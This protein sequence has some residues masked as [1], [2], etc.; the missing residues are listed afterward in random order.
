MAFL[1]FMFACIPLSCKKTE[2]EQPAPR[3]D[4]NQFIVTSRGDT[5]ENGFWN[6]NV[7]STGV[8]KQG[9]YKNGY[10]TGRW[11][12][13]TIFDSV[14]IEWSVV[15][16]KNVKFNVPGH[17]KPTGKE[18]LPVLYHADIEDNDTNTY[19]TLARHERNKIK[20]CLYYVYN[21]DQAL[22]SDTTHVILSKEFKKFHFTEH[23]IFRAKIVTE[24]GKR[25]E[26]IT[27]VFGIGNVLYDLT[28]KHALHNSGVIDLEVVNDI[29]YSME[30]NNVDVF[31][32]HH[33]NYF[34]EENI[35]FR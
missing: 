22:K 20:T 35:T 1:F 3:P 17:V 32:H 28:Y 6:Y 7:D 13:E 29:L 14:D 16:L 24:M 12:Y 27:Y 2:P 33:K 8:S 15:D 30:C 10:K 11:T 9:H 21:L 4:Q 31:S 18:R 25:Y 5:L 19:F 34:K 23:E 26:T